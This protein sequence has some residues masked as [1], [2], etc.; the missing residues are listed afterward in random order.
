MF[1]RS[2]PA[3]LVLGLAAAMTLTGCGA[4]DSTGRISVT[5]SGN[6]ADHPYEV[7]VFVPNGRI[8]AHQRV[9]PGG[10]VDFAGVAVGKVTVR[11]NELCPQEATV[12]S[13]EVTDVTLTS[14]GC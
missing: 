6:E 3:A 13:G 12:R 9:F 4:Q 1:R 5:V 11:A 8:A 10:T 14:S 2:A 7:K